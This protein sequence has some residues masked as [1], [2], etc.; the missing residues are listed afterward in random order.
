[1]EMMIVKIFVL[2]KALLV[3]VFRGIKK[4]AVENF[5]LFFEFMG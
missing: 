4:P 2:R 5:R 1:M 3:A